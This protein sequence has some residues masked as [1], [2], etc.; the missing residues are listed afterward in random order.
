MESFVYAIFLS[1][2]EKLLEISNAEK[3]M[4]KLSK[5][6]RKFYSSA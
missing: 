1:C 6:R 2:N 3:S 5:K 4:L